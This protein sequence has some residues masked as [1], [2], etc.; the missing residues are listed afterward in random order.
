M[1]HG[2]KTMLTKITALLLSGVSEE[3]TNFASAARGA[4]RWSRRHQ[5]IDFAIFKH[6]SYFFSEECA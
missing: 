4:H 5:R 6:L 1:H 3:A 2:E